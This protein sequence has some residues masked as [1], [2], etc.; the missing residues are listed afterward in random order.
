LCHAAC[1]QNVVSTN[2]TGLHMPHNASLEPINVTM[3][4]ATDLTGFSRRTL[5]R[6]VAAGH[7]R[8]VKHGTTSLLP[9]A[10]LKRYAMALDEAQIRPD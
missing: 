3:K 1:A 2:S 9:W 4:T 7:I 6:L 8:M 10:P 5:Y